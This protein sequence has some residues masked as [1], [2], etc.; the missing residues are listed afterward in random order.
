MQ[1]FGQQS[2]HP[3]SFPLRKVRRINPVGIIASQNIRDGKG[4]VN[5][6]GEAGARSRSPSTSVA[7]L[8]EGNVPDALISSV[9]DLPTGAVDDV[10]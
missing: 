7:V 1:T 5:L 4:A 10:R 6:G 9:P 8:L 2:M 3:H